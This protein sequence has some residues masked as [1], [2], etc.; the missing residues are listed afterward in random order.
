[1]VDKLERLFILLFY[2]CLVIVF[3]DLIDVNHLYEIELLF[4]NKKLLLSK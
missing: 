2:I 1:M 3:D 4:P